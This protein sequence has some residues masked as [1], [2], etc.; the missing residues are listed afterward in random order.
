M[1]D[2]GAAVGMFIFAVI[3]AV[4]MCGFC[5][6]DLNHPRPDP[7]VVDC[8]SRG[9]EYAYDSKGSDKC[10]KDGVIIKVYTNT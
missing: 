1:D 3:V 4:V 6:W 8:Q 7:N 5:V 9:G 10:Y 2:D